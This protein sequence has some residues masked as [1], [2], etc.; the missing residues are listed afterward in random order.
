MSVELDGEGTGTVEGKEFAG[1]SFLYGW[2][3][4]LLEGSV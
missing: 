1:N 2:D 4:I 3:G